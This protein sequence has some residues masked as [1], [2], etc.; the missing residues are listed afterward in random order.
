[1]PIKALLKASEI[2]EFE[3]M[4]FSLRLALLKDEILVL[5]WPY[6]HSLVAKRY[7]LKY[8]ATIF[9]VYMCTNS[10]ADQI[11]YSGLF[12]DPPSPSRNA[13]RNSPTYEFNNIER[14]NVPSLPFRVVTQWIFL[15]GYLLRFNSSI[16]C[17]WKYLKSSFSEVSHIS[18]C[19]NFIS[20][21]ESNEFLTKHRSRNLIVQY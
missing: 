15:S 4:P 6:R 13:L 14:I 20:H 3:F 8:I 10:R 17:V 2:F 11:G 12:T 16:Q 9:A 19:I 5:A 1:M 7:V 21:E 18:V